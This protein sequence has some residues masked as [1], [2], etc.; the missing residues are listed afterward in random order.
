M[1]PKFGSM[2]RPSPGWKIELH[3]DHG[4][5]VGL[6]EEGR[7]AIS[8]KPRP[9][10]M[11]REYLNNE[12][13]NKKSFIGDWYYTGDKAYKDEDGYLWFIGRDD[14]VIK[15]SGYRIGPFEVESALIE[16]PAVQEAAVV[17]SPDDIRG[18]IVKAFI[19]LKPDVKPSESLVREIQ[20]H[21]KN[22]T[23]PYK[24]PRAIEFVDSLPKT[25]SG[26]IRRNELREREMKKYTSESNNIRK[27]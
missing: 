10:G 8:T 22:V 24:Y 26:K 14:D 13:E 12:D 17:G 20:T 9:V 11:F 15:A 5:P 18:L 1:Q 6:H 21:V 27:S 7:I 2:G 4:K 19:I 25:I 3:D 23:A 16:H